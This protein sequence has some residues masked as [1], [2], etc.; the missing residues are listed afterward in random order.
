[1]ASTTLDASAIRTVGPLAVTRWAHSLWKEF[2]QVWQL[3]VGI[4]V[5][6]ACLQ[7]LMGWL[8]MSFPSEFP[9]LSQ[10]AINI[11][12]A[13]PTLIAIACSGV[14]IGQERQNGCW[15][16][17][18]SLPISWR[19]SLVS[20]VTTWLVASIFLV[21]VMLCIAAIALSMN[22]RSLG[23][24]L[25]SEQT[26]YGS[27]TYLL[28]LVIGVQVFIYCSIATLLIKDTLMAIVVAALSLFVFHFFVAIKNF[29]NLFNWMN[30]GGYE[31]HHENA[32]LLAYLA[33]FV[34]GS[35]WLA[36]TYRWR[37]G[38]GQNS[39]LSTR[40]G[41][42]ANY[43]RPQ[44]AAWMAFAGAVKQPSEFG[45]LIQHGIRSSLGLRAVVF[46]GALL[47]LAIA[48]NQREGDQLAPLAAC[49][50][51]C[52][53]G[54]SVFS[55]DQSLNRFRFF[56]DRGVAWKKLMI[57][58]VAPPAVLASICTVLACFLTNVPNTAIVYTF[59]VPIFVVGMFSSLV[60]ASPIVS[61][62]AA[63]TM[64]FGAI[65]LS[66]SAIA[67]WNVVAPGHWLSVAIWFPI[68]TLIV[69]FVAVRLVPRW[70][71]KDRL[72]STG[73][74]FGTM[75]VAV[76]LPGVLG[77]SFGFEQIPKVAWHG[78]P[79][80]EI[81]DID[82]TGGPELEVGNLSLSSERSSLVLFT[83]VQTGLADSQLSARIRDEIIE[84]ERNIS[85][86]F[87]I[88][89]K[90]IDASE[91]SGSRPQLANTQVASGL[92]SVIERTAVVAL[93]ATDQRR[94]D[95]AIRA[96]KANRKLIA[97][98]QQ[99]ALLA[100]TIQ[101]S[102]YVWEIWNTLDDNS[103]QFLIDTQE[104]ENLIPVRPSLEQF[105]EVLMARATLQRIAIQSTQPNLSQYSNYTSNRFGNLPL[106]N[107]PPIRWAYER[108]LALA[109]SEDLGVT[110]R[111]R[112]TTHYN[113][114]HDPL[115]REYIVLTFLE[116]NF[117]ERIRR[118][119]NPT[120]DEGNEVGGLGQAFTP[121]LVQPEMDFILHPV[122]DENCE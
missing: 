35:I 4:A 56:A 81:K 93:I 83:D 77:L 60:F 1:M 102:E 84:R 59:C 96:W 85:A 58:H 7:L 36:S 69:L 50:A 108:Q 109:L 87:A 33:S 105:R 28:T 66:G 34:V 54:V 112:N 111:V 37:W 52:V 90:L 73:I 91:N 76:L 25:F 20:K 72:D 5:I 27:W 116:A 121:A 110:S 63:M 15:A 61:I 13:S 26:G 74:Y 16:W 14:L 117:A 67:I 44:R 103:L 115:A 47:I 65:A 49:V 55:G 51:S 122:V 114:F 17:N 8:E 75:L 97:F 2:R 106:R 22:Q 41:S 94:K 70:L 43:L 45:M 48:A 21:A 23:Q 119:Q 46:L 80:A 113:F 101:S 11:A 88:Q 99:P 86:W 64:T 24:V 39:T 78:A 98:C 107:Y 42:P 10:N 95:L 29:S 68:S 62:T 18:S 120:A 30:S 53:L 57:S 32:I 31:L 82:W 6:Q 92:R 89:S 19:R 40:G 3:I 118:L 9:G 71:I 79:L 104:I 100:A 12:L 38:V